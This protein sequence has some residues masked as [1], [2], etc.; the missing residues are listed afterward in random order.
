MSTIGRFWADERHELVLVLG[1]GAVRQP[2]ASSGETDDLE[3]HRHL[4][5]AR[6]PRSRAS[7]YSEGGR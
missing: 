7:D 4:G 6:W 2:N 1:A 3:L 5:A